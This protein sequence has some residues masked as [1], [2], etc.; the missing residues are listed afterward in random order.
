MAI[1]VE[2]SH[3]AVHALAHQVGHV[4]HGENIR[5]L[6]KQHA[7]VVG[8]ALAGFYLFQDRLQAR[9]VDYDFHSMSAAQKI[10]NNMLT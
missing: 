10:K 8:Q 5:R 9:I 2:V 6:V 4:T 3:R 1:H 7:I